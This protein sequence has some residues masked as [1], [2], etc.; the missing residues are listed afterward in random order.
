MANYTGVARSNDFEVR[1]EKAFLE[2]VVTIPGVV[3]YPGTQPGTFMLMAEGTG[4][5]ASSAHSGSTAS[6]G[7]PEY[8]F[9]DGGSAGKKP[10]LPAELSEHLAPRSV[11]V[12]EEVGFLKVRC[13][14][15]Q[16]TAVNHRGETITVKLDDVYE[17]AKRAGWARRIPQAID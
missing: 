2:W 15:G 11:A 16:A 6:S 3:A 9:P 17:Q 1:D 12:L 10:D 13:L 4:G 7:W 8:R 5:S 14:V